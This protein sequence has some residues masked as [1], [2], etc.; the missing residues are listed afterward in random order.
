MPNR[1][2]VACASWREC[3]WQAACGQRRLLGRAATCG[4]GLTT[5]A[6]RAP[7]GYAS[8]R[9][10]F[11]CAGTMDWPYALRKSVHTADQAYAFTTCLFAKV[12]FKRTTRRWWG[13]P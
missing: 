4:G 10:R 13:W 8:V 1:K 12:L 9:R 3:P 6:R 7:S 5:D 2:R 11:F